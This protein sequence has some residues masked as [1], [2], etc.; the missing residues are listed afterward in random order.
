MSAREL[1]E[2]EKMMKYVDLNI[3]GFYYLFYIFFS[4]N[5][6]LPD[7][8]DLVDDLL[9][10]LTVDGHGDLLG[11]V[12]AVQLAHQLRLALLQQ[13][14]EHLESLVYLRL[15]HL[16]LERKDKEIGISRSNISSFIWLI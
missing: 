1:R 16:N 13:R 6:L 11:G 4:E 8:K 10:L 14:G 12:H 9:R 3:Q 5:L 7:L 15:G 2:S